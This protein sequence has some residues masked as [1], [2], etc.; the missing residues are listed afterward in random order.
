[1]SA[2]PAI[3][4]WP[5]RA[6]SPPRR[7][8]RRREPIRVS[9]LRATPVTEPAEPRRAPF[10]ALV[11]ALVGA[12]LIALLVLNTAIAADSFTQR[13]LTDQVEQLTIQEQEL[14]MQVNQAQAPAAL[15]RAATDLGM[16]PASTP[17]FV[18]VNPDG[19]SKVVV[20]ATPATRPPPPPG[21]RP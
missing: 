9:L 14:Q 21:P 8:S 18:V 2:L 11:L 15:A 12:G 1:M 19:T 3:D 7:T 6:P 5:G 4:S 13:S 20:P 10:V 17:G 16:I